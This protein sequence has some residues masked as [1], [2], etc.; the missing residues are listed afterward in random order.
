MANEAYR[1][2]D[3]NKLSK[4]IVDRIMNVKR[5]NCRSDEVKEII[6]VI[7]AYFGYLNIK[8]TRF[9]DSVDGIELKEIMV[10]NEFKDFIYPVWVSKQPDNFAYSDLRN[11]SCAD[12][13]KYIGKTVTDYLYY[14]NAVG[15]LRTIFKWNSNYNLTSLDTLKVCKS[16]DE[17][18]PFAEID[19]YVQYLGENFHIPVSLKPELITL[20]DTS[21]W[22]KSIDLMISDWTRNLYVSNI[23]QNSVTV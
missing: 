17:M 3:F 6:D 13:S 7:F 4:M 11:L 1:S 2:F 20:I 22:T 10:P 5:V 18:L 15:K 12:Y 19:G 9:V 16:F 21:Y 8:V 23:V 14:W